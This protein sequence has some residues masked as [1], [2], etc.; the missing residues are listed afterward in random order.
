MKLKS[1]IGYRAYQK[2][3]CNIAQ[4]ESNKTIFYGV[5]FIY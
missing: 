2:P 5:N 1:K 3:K 4:N